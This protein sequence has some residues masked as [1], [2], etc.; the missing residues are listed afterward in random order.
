MSSWPPTVPAGKAGRAG[1][2]GQE[3][4]SSDPLLWSNGVRA[5]LVARRKALACLAALRRNVLRADTSP[6]GGRC[7]VEGKVR[8]LKDF[9]AEAA[10]AFD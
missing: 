10:E 3:R 6:T 8:A 9:K 7:P 2:L 5:L 4:S 1:E